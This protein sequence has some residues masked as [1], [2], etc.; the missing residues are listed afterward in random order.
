[1]NHGF[2]KMLLGISI[3]ALSFGLLGCGG[4]SRPA[5]FPALAAENSEPVALASGS[6]DGVMLLESTAPAL[7]SSDGVLLTPLVPSTQF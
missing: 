7:K 1:M 2:R 4:S 3:L 5:L 6:L